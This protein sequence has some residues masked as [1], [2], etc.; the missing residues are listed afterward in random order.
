[1]MEWI[2][3]LTAATNSVMS[4]LRRK[5]GRA[6]PWKIPFV[7]V[8]NESWGCGGNMTPEFYADNFRRYNSS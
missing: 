4:D 6:E 8:G 7:G 3:Y 1:M 2:E 5:N